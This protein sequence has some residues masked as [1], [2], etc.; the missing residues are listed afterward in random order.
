MYE[1]VED[2]G[3][4]KLGTNWVLT[5]KIINGEN[6]VKARLTV[7]GDQDDASGIRKD[8]PT[9]RKG[10]IKIFSTIAA[11]E[12]WEIKSSDVTCAFLQGVDIERD[13]FLLPPKER[14]VPGMLWKLLKP[15][16]GLVDAPRGW[17]LDLAMYLNFS[18]SKG[19]RKIEGMA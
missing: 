10:N 19:E 7:R 15:V 13:V 14:R 18:M 4:F 16:Y 2:E 1:E 8:S 12:K 5:E 6:G 11:K 9:F 17:L 3:Q